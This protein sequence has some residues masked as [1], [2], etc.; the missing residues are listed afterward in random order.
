MKQDKKSKRSKLWCNSLVLNDTLF[1]KQ[2]EMIYKCDESW[3][4][5]SL[6][7][8]EYIVITLLEKTIILNRYS[9]LSAE[10]LCYQNLINLNMMSLDRG[11]WCHSFQVVLQILITAMAYYLQTPQSSNLEPPIRVGFTCQILN[12]SSQCRYS[13]GFAIYLEHVRIKCWAIFKRDT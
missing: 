12:Y 13:L 1:T 10:Y 4:E 7:V 3:K 8:A 9:S 6:R 5:S 2:T 11:K